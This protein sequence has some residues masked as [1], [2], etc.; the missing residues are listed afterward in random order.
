MIRSKLRA[1]S[2]EVAGTTL[3]L[4][5]PLPVAT[6]GTGIKGSAPPKCMFEIRITIK[7]YAIDTQKHL[8]YFQGSLVLSHL[9]CF[10]LKT[11]FHNFLIYVIYGR[12]HNKC[13]EYTEFIRWN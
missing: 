1:T 7:G 9:I 4:I 5:W 13:T 8:F 10:T 2:T 3:E 12:C 6:R 11:T